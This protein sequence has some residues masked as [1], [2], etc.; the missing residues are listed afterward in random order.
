[1]T[2]WLARA[3]AAG[4]RR[5]EEPRNR[6]A[7]FTARW[8]GP[9]P[10]VAASRFQD[11]SE[12]FPRHWRR[13][14]E[15]WSAVDAA[16]PV[17]RDALADALEELPATWRAVVIA[18]DALDQGADEVGERLG[19]TG[20]QQRAILNRARARLRERLAHRLRVE[21]IA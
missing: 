10:T 3:G 16:E 14:P 5:S 1:V 6:F 9:T 13:F 2:G 7:R 20:P 11:E 15:P 21:Q 17:V 4:V 19:L 18:R 8:L 12:P